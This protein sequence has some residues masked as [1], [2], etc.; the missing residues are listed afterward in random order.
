MNYS[1]VTQE[2][3]SD[4]AVLERELPFEPVGVRSLGMLVMNCP[5]AGYKDQ[6]PLIGFISFLSKWK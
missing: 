2:N 1:Q 4:T 6:A 5:V 3:S